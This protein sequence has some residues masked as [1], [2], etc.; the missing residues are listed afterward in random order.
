M[1]G[2]L[3]VYG[4]LKLKRIAGQVL[5]ACTYG[6]GTASL[7][8]ITWARLP[9]PMRQFM[10]MLPSAA[11]IRNAIEHSPSPAMESL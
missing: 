2:Q 10:M 6:P 7:L 4:T 11:E 8:Q 3:R 1:C 5:R 9:E